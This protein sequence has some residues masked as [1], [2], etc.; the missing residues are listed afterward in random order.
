MKLSEFYEKHWKY[1]SANG[2]ISDPPKLSE[3]EKQSMDLS[4]ELGLPV[5]VIVKGRRGTHFDFHP[6]IKKRLEG[7]RSK[8][9]EQ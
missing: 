2:D 1:K 8:N 3:R 5:Y 7:I 9:E 4:E 6:E